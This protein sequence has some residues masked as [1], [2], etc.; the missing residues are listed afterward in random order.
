MS[1]SINAY[2][3]L[4]SIEMSKKGP[5]IAVNHV[6]EDGTAVSVA[7]LSPRSAFDIATAMREVSEIIMISTS[8]SN[9]VH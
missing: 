1:K 8:K 2:A 6:M 3:V 9:T 5:A 7:L 4:L